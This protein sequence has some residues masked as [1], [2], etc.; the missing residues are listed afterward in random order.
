MMTRQQREGGRNFP[1]TTP[2]RVHFKIER[3]KTKREKEQ[4]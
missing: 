4:S 2:E 1:K 3:E